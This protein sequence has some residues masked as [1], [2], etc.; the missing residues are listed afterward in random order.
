MDMEQVEENEV[1]ILPPRIYC[2]VCQ[3]RVTSWVSCDRCSLEICDDCLIMTHGLGD[4]EDL[5]VTCIAIMHQ[6]SRQNSDFIAEAGQLHGCDYCGFES[7][8]S[9]TIYNGMDAYCVSCVKKVDRI[10]ENNRNIVRDVL[11]S[12]NN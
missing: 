6:L 5:C 9:C 2:G 7:C 12:L 8:A 10:Y 11:R 1:I 4:R 3:A